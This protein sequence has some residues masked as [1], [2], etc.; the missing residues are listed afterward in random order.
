[1][2]SR[3]EFTGTVSIFKVL[4]LKRQFITKL[5]AHS[6]AFFVYKNNENKYLVHNLKN[7]EGKKPRFTSQNKQQREIHR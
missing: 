3:P 4:N 6:A 7:K 5:E 2:S 1:V